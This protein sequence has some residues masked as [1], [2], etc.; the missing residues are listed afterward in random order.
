LVRVPWIRRP[1]AACAALALAAALLAPSP[2]FARDEPRQDAVSQEIAA[3]V[4]GRVGALSHA[5]KRGA[6]SPLLE[7]RGFGTLA[8]R[9]PD[10]PRVRAV[11][12]GGSPS[13]LERW[14]IA[15]ST[16][17]SSP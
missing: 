7:R 17:T 14:R 1:T 4:P 13:A 5:P 15:H 3:A 12:L 2:G 11:F 8:V 6:E 16:S 9:R 10:P